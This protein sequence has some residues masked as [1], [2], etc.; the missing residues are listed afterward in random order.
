M[1]KK[2]YEK[3]AKEISYQNYVFRAYPET[4]MGIQIVTTTLAQIFEEDNPRFDKEIF[5]KACKA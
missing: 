3:I 2:D 1:T 4:L 5:Y